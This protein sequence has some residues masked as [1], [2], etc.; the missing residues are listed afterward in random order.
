MFLRPFEPP[1]IPPKKLRAP[2][3]ISR[4]LHPLKPTKEGEGTFFAGTIRHKIM[5]V[6]VPRTLYLIPLPMIASQ[7]ILRSLR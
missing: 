3:D 2:T 1:K 7:I 6:L 4:A 5:I